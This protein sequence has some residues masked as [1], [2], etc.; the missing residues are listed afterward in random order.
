MKPVWDAEVSEI[1]DGGQVRALD[2]NL[3]VDSA[4]VV[5]G[6]MDQ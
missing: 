6:I 1:V 4:K 2:A 5:A 3:V